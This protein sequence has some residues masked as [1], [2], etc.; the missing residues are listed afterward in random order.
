MLEFR[1]N[2]VLLQVGYDVIVISLHGFRDI[3][4][5]FQAGCDIIVSSRPGGAARTFHDGFAMSGHDFWIVIHTNFLSAMH[6][7]RDNVVLL[8]AVYAVIVI[9]PPRGAPGDIL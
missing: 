8:Q 6:G 3:T 1:E 5:V 9:L 4:V 2:E 7:F